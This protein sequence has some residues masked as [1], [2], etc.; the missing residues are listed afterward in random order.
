MKSSVIRLVIWNHE[1]KRICLWRVTPVAKRNVV[2]LSRTVK[3]KAKGF[4]LSVYFK[5][6]PRV[7]LLLL[8]FC[9]KMR[10]MPKIDFCCPHPDSGSSS[11][12]VIDAQT[13]SSFRNPK[14]CYPHA[15]WMHSWFSNEPF[16]LRFYP[17]FKVLL[18]IRRRHSWSLCSWVNT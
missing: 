2:L 17:S 3:E 11:N 6:K 15:S 1:N 13:T 5:K 10:L 9:S 7:N 8:S 18:Q 16:N 12:L 4:S 14:V